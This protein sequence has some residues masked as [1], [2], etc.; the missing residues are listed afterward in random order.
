MIQKLFNTIK[1]YY[2]DISIIVKLK[3]LKDLPTPK[4]ENGI[5]DI[6]YIF[7]DN[8]HIFKAKLKVNLEVDNIEFSTLDFIDAHTKKTLQSLKT[9]R[10]QCNICGENNIEFLQYITNREYP[11][12]SSCGSN[13]RFRSLIS[14]LIQCLYDKQQVLTDISSNKSIS[15]LGMSDWNGYAKPLSQHFNYINT[16]YHKAPKLDICNIS[17]SHLSKY[18]FV[19]SSDV[20]EHIPLPVEIA[21]KNLLLLLKPGG[22]CFL[23]VPYTQT[24]QTD[25]HFPS[26]CDYSIESRNGKK[27]LKNKTSNGTIEYFDNLIFHGGGGDTLEMRIFSK[28]DLIKLL[29]EAGFEDIT[30]YDKDIVEYGVIWPEIRVVTIIARKPLGAD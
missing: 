1:T 2:H 19:I 14:A 6:P 11:S 20:F 29:L 10:F 15:G 26:L 7:A 16:F 8:N 18:D 9:H 13:L 12:C 17:N 25:E 4:L 30:F 27:I 23:S 22:R 3:I 28:P 5:L 24:G 21:F